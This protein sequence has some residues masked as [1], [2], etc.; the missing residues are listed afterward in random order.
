MLEVQTAFRLMP[1]PAFS[2]LVLTT[3]KSGSEVA[4]A[5]MK[6]GTTPSKSTPRKEESLSR[7]QTEKPVKTELE[8]IPAVRRKIRKIRKM[9]VTI[10]KAATPQSQRNSTQTT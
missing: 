2:Q 10:L 7:M 5:Q 4:Q 3:W 9:V 6:S 1:P 8:M